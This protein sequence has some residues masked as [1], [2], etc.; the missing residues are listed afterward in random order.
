MSGEWKFQNPYV[1]IYKHFF[2]L[3]FRSDN[4]NFL[5]KNWIKKKTLAS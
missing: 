2:S 1:F 5:I 4:V 3:K